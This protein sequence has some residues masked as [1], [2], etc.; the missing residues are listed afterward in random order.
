MI[1][2]NIVGQK[3]MMPPYAELAAQGKARMSTLQRIAEFLAATSAGIGA[4]YGIH[5]NPF[6]GGLV[7]FGAAYGAGRHSQRAAEEYAQKKIDLEQARELRQYQIEKLKKP[8]KGPTVP[9]APWYLQPEWKET[10]EGKAAR[11]K[12]EHVAS[13][14]PKKTVGERAGEQIDIARR[15]RL[16]EEM[17]TLDETTDP[18]RLQRVAGDPQWLPETRKAAWRKY[19]LIPNTFE[20]APPGAMPR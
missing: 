8:E 10:P 14:A 1:N 4:S 7:G 15:K 9:Q 17:A 13:G 6:A 19:M 20:E 5:D 18:I 3:P 11:A 2:Y 16:A 12:A